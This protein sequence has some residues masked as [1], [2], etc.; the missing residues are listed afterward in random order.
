MAEQNFDDWDDEEDILPSGAPLT[1]IVVA[2][3]TNFLAGT[4]AMIGGALIAAASA[5]ALDVAMSQASVQG[6]DAERVRSIASGILSLISLVL[7]LFGVAAVA[8]GV[9]VLKRQ[10]WGRGLSIVLAYLAGALAIVS[11]VLTIAYGVV[12]FGAHA[13][14]M[15]LVLNDKDYSY[16]F[17]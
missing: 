8:A 9:G 7:I 2:A 3:V 1:G 11:L 15:L 10:A 5:S 17:R 4:L 14:V 12:I 13:L 6:P 16:Q